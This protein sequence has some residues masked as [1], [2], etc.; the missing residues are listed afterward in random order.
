LDIKARSNQGELFNIEI[1]LIDDGDYSKRALYYWSKLYTEQLQEGDSYKNLKKTIGIHILNFNCILE[2]EKY[3]N[4]FQL[5]EIENGIHYFT[6]IELHTIELKKFNNNP[7]EDKTSL[8][9]KIRNSL[10]MWVA[11]LTRHDLLKVDALPQD[12]DSKPLVKAYN[13]LNSINFSP[14]EREFYESRLKWIRLEA[15][16]LKQAEEKSF[17][18]GKAE[19]LAE[20]E[21]RAKVQ[22]AKELIKKRV[23]DLQLIAELTG[24]PQEDLKTIQNEIEKNGFI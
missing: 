15:G 1:Q 2:S 3:H 13:V 21:L 8:L 12:L 9:L 22:L 17:Q 16:V 14:E 23:A 10:D 4:L 7:S 11:F 6:D 18:I 19:G 5:K 20:G 24:L